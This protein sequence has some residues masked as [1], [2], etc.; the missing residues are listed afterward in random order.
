MVNL[1]LKFDPDS[2]YFARFACF[3]VVAPVH[4]SLDRYVACNFTSGKETWDQEKVTGNLRGV[5]G[6]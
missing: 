3:Q 2:Y 5:F 6:I 1:Y 4:S